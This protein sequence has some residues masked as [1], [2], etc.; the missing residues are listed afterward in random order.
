MRHIAEGLL[1]EEKIYAVVTDLNLFVA[2][3]FDT[4]IFVC[5]DTGDVEDIIEENFIAKKGDIEWLTIRCIEP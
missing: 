1:G 3:D 2:A 5:K 4:D